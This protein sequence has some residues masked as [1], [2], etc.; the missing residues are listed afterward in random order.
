MLCFD[1]SDE[2][3]ESHGRVTYIHVL[4]LCLYARK[5]SRSCEVKL[6]DARRFVH[7]SNILGDWSNVLEGSTS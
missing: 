4:R 7:W 3:I 2:R 5:A 6:E 1:D